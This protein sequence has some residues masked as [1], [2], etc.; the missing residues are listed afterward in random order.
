MTF[1][2]RFKT[3]SLAGLAALFISACGGGSGG[4][5]D[6]E[7]EPPTEP[8]ISE[9]VDFGKTISDLVSEE[10]STTL[11]D[12]NTFDSESNPIEIPD[13]VWDI[14]DADVDES[15]LDDIFSG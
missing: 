8:P 7:I 9:A 15:V 11:P 3:L 12:G 14:D 10:G 2:H 1:Q 6:P 4:S 5:N 13:Y